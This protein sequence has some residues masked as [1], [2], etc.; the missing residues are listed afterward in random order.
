MTIRFYKEAQ[1]LFSHNF[2]RKVLI[3]VLSP[4]LF[5][6]IL[7]YEYYKHFIKFTFFLLNSFVYAFH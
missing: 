2:H 7:L 3:L 1:Q 5:R 6:A 4:P